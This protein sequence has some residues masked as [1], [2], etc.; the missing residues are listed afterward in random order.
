MRM[1]SVLSAGIWWIQGICFCGEEWEI[2]LEISSPKMG[3]TSTATNAASL[4]STKAIGELTKKEDNDHYT[5][6]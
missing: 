1:K 2:K 5:A 3:F 4:N 6:L